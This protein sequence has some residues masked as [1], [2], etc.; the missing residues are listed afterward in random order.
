MALDTTLAGAAADS[1]VTVADAETYLGTT[2]HDLTGWNALEEA[3]K[4]RRLQLAALIV[5]SV[6]PFRGFPATKEQARKWPRI[7]PGDDLFVDDDDPRENSFATWTDLTDYADLLGLEEAALPDLPDA[8]KNAQA[9]VAFQVVHSHLLTL[10][11]AEAGVSH[12]MDFSLEGLRFSEKTTYSPLPGSG[13]IKLARFD[14]LS[15][16]KLYLYPYIAA[17]RGNLI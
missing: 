12:S 11:A 9:E 16:V 13:L 10:S 17:V 2:E 1:Y 4:E 7:F 3:G 8:L 5:D 15:V 14:A 6:V